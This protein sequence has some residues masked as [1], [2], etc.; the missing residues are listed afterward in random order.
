MAHTTRSPKNRIPTGY[1]QLA[2][3]AS[4]PLTAA[5]NAGGNVAVIKAEVQAVRWRDDG[6]PPTAAVGFPLAVGE[7]YE[8]RGDLA[9]FRVIAQVAG[10]LLNVSYYDERLES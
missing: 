8:Y 6:T 5:A 10:G 2:C 1:E 7:I 9:K 3:N 4:T